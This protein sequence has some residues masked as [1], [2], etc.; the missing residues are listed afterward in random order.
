MRPL[1]K[2]ITVF[3]LTVILTSCGNSGNDSNSVEKLDTKVTLLKEEVPQLKTKK[4]DVGKLKMDQDGYSIGERSELTELEN[5]LQDDAVGTIE[6]TWVWDSS[7]KYAD[8]PMKI[9]YNKIEGNLKQIFTQNNVIEEYKNIMPKCLL[10]FLENGEKSF[11]LLE[12]YCK[13]AK[14]NFNNTEMT[15]KTAGNKPEQ[16]ELDGSVKIVKEFIKENAKDASSIKFIEWSKVSI[17]GEFWVVRCKYKGTNAFGGVVTENMWF[18]IQKNQVVK[19]K[20][21]E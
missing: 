4:I 8:M 16:N 12:D 5:Q 3:I 20:E 17:F 14:Y 21:M 6:I 18:Y 10:E 9:I 11:Y 7:P 1:E 19:T 15:N 2:L 13:D